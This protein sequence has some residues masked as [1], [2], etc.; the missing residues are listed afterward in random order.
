MNILRALLATALL[1][2]LAPSTPAR[3]STAKQQAEPPVSTATRRQDGTWEAALSLLVSLADE[4]RTFRDDGLGA[5]VQARAA[6][7]LW[8]EQPDTARAIFR[9]A[10]EQAERADEESQKKVDEAKRHYF[11]GTDKG[12]VMIPNPSNFRGEIINMVGRRERG[13]TEEFLSQLAKP[14]EPDA[15]DAPR[16]LVASAIAALD[17]PPADRQRLIL[18]KDLLDAGDTKQALVFADPALSGSVN[19]PVIHFLSFLR[20]KAPQEADTRFLRLCAAADS[21]PSSDANTVS[22]LSSYVFTPLLVIVF[23]PKGSRGSSSWGERPVQPPDASPQV[24]AAFFGA[25]AAILLRPLPPPEQDHTSAGR[26]GLYMEITRLLPVFARYAP[27]RVAE[28]EARRAE[29]VQDTP[30]RSRDERRIRKWM[31][32]EQ[33]EDTPQDNSDALAK[34][35][36]QDERDAI[37]A[38]WALTINRKDYEQAR[39]RAMK[40]EN[41]EVRA[42]FLAL[43]TLDEAGRLVKK[44]D[45]DAAL[46]L[47][48]TGALSPAQLVWLYC[49]CARLLKG[50]DPARAQHLV[51]E[52][53]EAAHQ[54]DDR[55]RAR[56]H[57]L[58]AV[59][60]ASFYLDPARGWSALDEA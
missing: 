43:L 48:A 55:S 30:E 23:D 10:W 9:R 53:A 5:S 42:Q 6:D 24:R 49:S 29:L 8:A 57:A 21:D 20:E 50:R 4:A 46:K 25:A 22:L 36:T 56:A 39:E 14:K 13:L 35:R 59:A 28:L 11:A 31:P 32:G 41:Q 12:P 44:E 26:A 7:L 19:L 18:A 33:S 27:E 52:A 17:A 1:A 45:A 2:P 3:Q 38:S 37:N 58:L 34:A 47:A 40:I 15:N 54:L 16:G 51:E 60:A